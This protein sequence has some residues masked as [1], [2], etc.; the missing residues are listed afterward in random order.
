MWPTAAPEAHP[1]AQ[2]D[3]PERRGA[4]SGPNPSPLGYRREPAAAAALCCWPRVADLAD[5]DHPCR[6]R[7]TES[8]MRLLQ[9][10]CE[11]VCALGDVASSAVMVAF[12]WPHRT[13]DDMN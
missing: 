5:L 7:H 3:L 6:H 2:G 12:F 13:A 9:R 10:Y 4:L 1:L 8:R 11:D